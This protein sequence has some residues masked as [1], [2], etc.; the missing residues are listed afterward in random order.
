MQI[1]CVLC[2]PIKDEDRPAFRSEIDKL[3]LKEQVCDECMSAFFQNIWSK[4][5]HEDESA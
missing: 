3:P 2:T 4:G 1:L 5:D